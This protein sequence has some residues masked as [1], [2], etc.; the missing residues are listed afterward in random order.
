MGC[1][2]L[3]ALAVVLG[4]GIGAVPIAP[5][6]TVRILLGHAGVPVEVDPQQDAVLWA[7]R[8]PRVLLGLLVGGALAVSGAALQGIFRNPLADPTIVGVASGASVG[9]VAAILLGLSGA[10]YGGIQGAAFVGGMA[11]VAVVYALA[12]HEGRTETVT[13]VLVGIA[14]TAIAGAL[15]GLMIASADDDELRDIVFWSLGS[16]GGATWPLVVAT[17]PFV[18]VGAVAALTQTRPLDLLALGER[19]ASH[20]GVEVERVRILLVVALALATSAAVAAAGIVAFVGLIV[21]HLDPARRRAVASRRPPREPARR[22]CRRR[23]RRPRRANRCRARG[24]AARGGHRARGRAAL[25]LAR[26]PHPPESRRLGVS[27]LR[28]AGLGYVVRG[29]RL[30]TG[31]DLELEAGELL[32]V[33][34]PNGAGKSTLLRLLAGD[35]RP[36][37][38][39][40]EL[41][42]A[43]VATLPRHELARRRAVMPQHTSIGFGFTVR[44]VVEM[45]C[46]PLRESYDGLGD[47]VAEALART[48]VAHLAERSF[49][50]LSGGEQALATFARV[51]AQCTPVLFLDE[52]TASLDLGH[53]EEVMRIARGVA[54]GGGGVVV[55]AHDLNLAAAYADRICLLHEGRVVTTGSPW[56]AL[57][58]PLLSDVF[59]QRMRVTESPDDGT[60][61]VVPV[62]FG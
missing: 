34:G 40:V 8:L 51:L 3:V 24:A 55:V 62:R 61:L 6:E 37:E 42:G 29:S 30:L 19:E 31:V 5:W 54:D 38:G 25:P 1:A 43:S 50:T 60:P 57:Q 26:A 58:E 17:A 59:G 10:V 46:H 33:V 53:Q 13:L 7:I 27:L 56:A 11:A 49:R 9:A 2:A 22:R 23:P 21:P 16:L 41:G 28:A 18:A 12:R 44:Q 15:V 48:G 52:P 45:G 36:T 14:V 35:T 47:V 32:A 20:L 4:V 39:T